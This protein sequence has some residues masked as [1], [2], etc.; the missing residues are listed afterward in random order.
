MHSSDRHALALAALTALGSDLVA[1]RGRVPKIVTDDDDGVDADDAHPK[2]GV[3]S[4]S[5]RSAR[6]RNS[7]SSRS[8][9]TRYTSRSISSSCSSSKSLSKTSHSKGKGRQKSKAKSTTSRASNS[10][11]STVGSTGER[12]RATVLTVAPHPKPE[13]YVP[14]P[15]GTFRTSYTRYLRSDVIGILVSE[16]ENLGMPEPLPLIAGSSRLSQEKQQQQQQQNVQTDTKPAL[17]KPAIYL[18]QQQLAK[19]PGHPPPVPPT[20]PI[21]RLKLEDLPPL[22]LSEF[23]FFSASRSRS[24]DIRETSPVWSR[25]PAA[26]APPRVRRWLK[27]ARKE[28]I[29]T[30][31]E[32]D[33]SSSQS[34][35]NSRDGNGT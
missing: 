28:P 6:S 10:K 12:R 34:T 3:R 25:S 14:P 15:R 7:T 1:M 21:S 35:G 20:A 18:N 23:D 17:S 32:V 16:I 30:V 29:G 19:R 24:S 4:R 5:K 13:K 8:T 26:P 31:E 2:R 22:G 11:A 9:R 27:N 33:D